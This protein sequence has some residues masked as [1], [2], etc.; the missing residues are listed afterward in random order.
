MTRGQ[1][2]TPADP[3]TLGAGGLIALLALGIAL[4]LQN[5]RQLTEDAD[6]VA[7]TYEV[8]D[9]VAEVRG[10]LRQTEAIQ[11]AFL[12]EGGS[13]IPEDLQ[14]NLE[15]ARSE[16]HRLH[17]LSA[18]SEEQLKRI[19]R[20]ESLVD[21]FQVEI[22]HTAEV[23][24]REGFEASRELVTRGK[25]RRLA[26]E[27]SDTLRQMDSAER[28]VLRERLV[29]KRG[30]YRRA[31]FVGT[32]LGLTGIGGL[33]ALIATQRRHVAHRVATAAEIADQR[34]RMATIV[35]SSNDAII[36]KSL[37]G[38]IASWNAAAERLLG[39]SAKE[40]IDQPVAMILPPGGEAEE[41]LLIDRLRKGERIEHFET[42]RV[43][44]DGR[45][46][47]VSLTLSPVY[48]GR[49]QINGAST[50]LRDIRDRKEA[51]RTLRDSEER[52]R[53]LA[54]NMSQFAWMA[55]PDGW[56]FWYNR[57][58]YEYTGTTLE[59]MQGWG[60]RKLHHPD[61]VDRVVERIQYSWDTGEEWEDLFPLRSRTGEYRWFLSRALPIRDSDGRIVRWL[62]T[63]TDVTEQREA[64]L[65]LQEADRR[66]NEF[67]A[68]LAHE[69]RNPL[70]PIRNGLELLD[71]ERAYDE[72][73]VPLMR[74]QV[75]QLIRL[76]EDLLDVSRIMRGKVEL[77]KAPVELTSIVKQSAR[78]VQDL[79]DRRGQTL[80]V[81]LPEDEIWLSADPVR[82]SQVVGNL[83]NN[84][85]KYSDAAG[86]IRLSVARNGEQ[87]TVEVRDDGMGI[88]PDLLPRVFDVFTQADRALD[89]SQGGLGIGLTVV[90]QLVE[91]HGGT[92]AAWSEGLG[93]GSTFTMSL[94]IDDSAKQEAQRASAQRTQRLGPPGKFKVLV[95]DDN[96][97]AAWMLS[98]LLGKIG[99]HEVEAVHDG[100]TAIAKVRQWMPDV[101]FL[102]IGLPGMDGYEV[103]RRLRIQPDLQ[104]LHL[105]ALTGY[106]QEEDRRRS[107][108]AGF[109]RHLV[110]PADISDIEE[111]FAGIVPRPAP[112]DSA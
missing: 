4:M 25:V 21:D 89:R 40:A 27:M 14:R 2:K 106:G 6:W 15:L 11:R 77:R 109:D 62:G 57:R 94:P 107:Q 36:S 12:I 31:L 71:R 78:G 45:L 100:A 63:N 91:L 95:V 41:T 47:D 59:E 9:A 82:L 66:K 103:A 17:G 88:E 37:D 74:Q 61:H 85:S 92:V 28:K 7:H 60:W 112:T 19:N 35:E 69:L 50:I 70:A 87:A 22:L 16:L 42:T 18:N 58:W 5:T 101:V 24:I 110:K 54:D 29:E 73:A 67:L 38:I 1:S 65:A 90:R 51:E 96:V 3:S 34:E 93:F 86:T 81:Q 10:R 80:C 8:M 43:H 53:T 52:F 76:V 99:D 111:I 23:R 68:M 98:R 108:A 39:Y 75:E 48:D 97:G 55:D 102:D 13:R 64:E 49:G 20:I 104:H 83:L 26:E 84:A 44:K 46:V 79:I 32:L 72:Q 105:I 30:S 56:I 33:V